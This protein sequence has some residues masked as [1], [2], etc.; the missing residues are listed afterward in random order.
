MAAEKQEC[1]ICKRMLGVPYLY[2]HMREVHGIY[3]GRSG[4]KRNDPRYNANRAPATPREI[5]DADRVTSQELV[6]VRPSKPKSAVFK[7]IEGM[8]VIVDDEGA[9]WIA[10][11]VRDA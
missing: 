11:K 10:E 2:Q 9:I 3:G 1:R 4:I 8:K 5:Q 6:P 7:E